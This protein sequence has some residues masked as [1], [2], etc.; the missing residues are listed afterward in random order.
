[1]DKKLTAY[2]INNQVVGID[3][4]TPSNIE[5][6]IF[7]L[8]DNVSEGYSDISSIINYHIF[9]VRDNLCSDFLQGKLIIK[10]FVENKGLNLVIDT[11]T[12]NT[13]LTPNINDKYLV[14]DNGVNDFLNQDGL[15]ATWNGSSWTF[16]T[17]V[18]EGFD[19]CTLEEK[20]ILCRYNIGS[21]QRQATAVSTDTLIKYGKDY[22]NNSRLCRNKRADKVITEIHNRLYND[23]SE[24]L[25]DILN[26]AYGNLKERYIEFGVLGTVVNDDT[27]L[28]DYINGTGL[29]NNTNGLRQ[30]SIIPSGMSLNDFCDKIEDLLLNG[31]YW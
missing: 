17:K 18:D 2:T 15:I 10:Q 30:K 4:L 19:L 23:K 31:N 16:N 11:V 9:M 24:I 1:M 12:D 7:R 13:T 21:Q 27:A 25:N 3:I 22:F 28:L 5:N 29:Y 26:S 20:D 14:G 6:P 8:E